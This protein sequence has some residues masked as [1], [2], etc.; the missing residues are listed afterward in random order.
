[1][2]QKVDDYLTFENIILG[3]EN[4][5]KVFKNID[6]ELKEVCQEKPLEEH[7]IYAIKVWNECVEGIQNKYVL[8]PTWEY[9]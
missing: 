4:K 3:P 9:N 8:G 6:V 7:G 5:T 1:M 2:Y